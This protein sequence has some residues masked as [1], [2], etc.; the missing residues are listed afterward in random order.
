MIFLFHLFSL[1]TSSSG[2]L[3]FSSSPPHHPAPV[4]GRG[5]TLLS[6]LDTKIINIILFYFFPHRLNRFIVIHI[7]SFIA[8]IYILYIY[9]Y[10]I[11]ALL[12]IHTEAIIRGKNATT[13]AAIS[14]SP[15]DDQDTDTPK[16]AGDLF[17]IAVLTCVPPSVLLFSLLLHDLLSLHEREIDSRRGCSSHPSSLCQTEIWKE[18]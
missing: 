12:N 11:R 14:A 16:K 9:T 18:L 6:I 17:L 2:M 1:R 10:Y 3:F 8:Y 7:H 5:P 4:P 15:V 13:P